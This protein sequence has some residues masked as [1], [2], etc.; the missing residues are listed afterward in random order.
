[1]TMTSA[2]KLMLGYAIA[3]GALAALVG[4]ELVVDFDRSK[5]PTDGGGDNTQAQTADGGSITGASE[6][7]PPVADGGSTSAGGG[8]PGAPSGLQSGRWTG[9]A[10]PYTTLDLTV[11]ESPS[12]DLTGML[13][14][15]V[16]SPTG[17]SCWANTNPVTVTG[18]VSGNT[19][20]M[21]TVA[22]ATNVVSFTGTI[23]QDCA[24]GTYVPV[25]GGCFSGNW[26]LTRVSK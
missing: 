3:L 1:M 23:G 2:R 11:T 20:T 16:T 13:T 7:G 8:C 9:S 25:Q 15:T 24:N 14:V 21:G 17:A 6:G 10:T 12:H 22:G 18:T 26:S 5:I 19:M 4:C